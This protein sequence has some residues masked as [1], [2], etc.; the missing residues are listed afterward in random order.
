[1]KAAGPLVVAALALCA[2]AA[3][4]SPNLAAAHDA[5]VY[6][7]LIDGSEP[8][9]HPHHLLFAPLAQLWIAALRHLGVGA[10]SSRLVALLDACAGAA[11]LAVVYALLRRRAEFGPAFAGVVTLCAGA[12]FGFWFYSVSVEVYMLPLALVLAALY[13][14]GGRGSLERRFAAAGALHG[15]AVLFHQLHVLFFPAVLWAA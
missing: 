14:L 11:G 8:A 15:A 6:M 10:E 5:V 3:T 2:Y 13:V 9:F 1:M 7:N 4:L 12:S